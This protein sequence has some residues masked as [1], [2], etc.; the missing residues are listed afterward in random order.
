[1]AAVSAFSSAPPQ[2]RH[3]VVSFPRPHI[4]LVTL[5]RPG[6]LNALHRATHA[7]LNRLWA[8]YDAE[9]SL[10]CAI[11]TGRGRAFCA[12]ADLREWKK[13]HSQSGAASSANDVS[14][15]LGSGSSSTRENG[16]GGMS[17]RRG[18]KPIVAAVNGLC[19]GGGMEM[20]VNA[21]LVIASS[22]A[23][24]GL[25]EVRRGV[26]ARAGALPRLIRTV[27]R[28]RA[29]EMAFLGRT[30]SAR[31]MLDWGIVNHV[32]VGDGQPVLDEALRWAAE[33]VANS[34]DS[35][36][37]SRA[38]LLGGWDGEDPQTSTSRVGNGIYRQLEEEYNIKEGLAS[39]VEKR[40]P[41]WE[42]SKL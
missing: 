17:D 26:V 5:D 3:V 31:Q 2:S 14:S 39:F 29:S 41:V 7:E 10:R 34:P 9:P 35:V 13:L 18:K 11:I 1:M 20:I 8:W 36:I 21:D 40:K 6:Q 38:G 4:L 19:L 25:P 23:Q 32:V 37:A 22:A 16:F 24:F 33:L 12:G 27:G 28:Q 30:Y 42:N 15:T